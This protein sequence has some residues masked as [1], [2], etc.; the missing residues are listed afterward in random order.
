[1]FG[2]YDCHGRSVFVQGELGVAISL[3]WSMYHRCG[4][5]VKANV[6]LRATKTYVCMYVCVFRQRP[7]FSPTT[8][9]PKPVF[10]KRY[11]MS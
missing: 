2:S 1:M 9:F 5:R 3:G 10:W 11:T 6:V 8:D 7:T 4:A